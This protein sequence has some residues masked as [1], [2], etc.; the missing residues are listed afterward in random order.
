MKIRG[1]VSYSHEDG[2][3]LTNDLVRYLTNLFPNFEPIYDE[4]VGEGSNI[5]EIKQKLSLC[6][7]LF[8]IITPASLNSIP[9]KEEVNFA[10][11]ENMKIIPCKDNYLQKK[12]E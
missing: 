7:V 6:D 8:I 11:K 3:V 9:I 5:E 10:I 12:L 4:N 2:S 1:F